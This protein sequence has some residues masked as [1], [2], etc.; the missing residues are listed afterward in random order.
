MFT[1]F[2]ILLSLLFCTLSLIPTA[3]RMH[4]RVL[5]GGVFVAAGTVALG[6]L[7]LL[8]SLILSGALLT[9]GSLAESFKG[10]ASDVW[11]LYERFTG[12]A[13]FLLALLLLAAALIRH[14]LFRMRAAVAAVAAVLLLI[15]GGAYG[16]IAATDGAE[17]LTPLYLWTVG[18]AALLQ[19]GNF[20]DILLAL[21]DIKR[22]KEE[23]KKSR[24]A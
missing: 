11:S 15:L 23:K 6:V 14:P 13:A 22:E 4:R 10:W 16:V 8:F 7:S 19:T 17:V 18:W 2:A 20:A 1:V 24:R 5:R 12:I 21:R 9:D 3:F